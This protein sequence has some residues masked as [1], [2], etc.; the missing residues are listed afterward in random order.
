MIKMEGSASWQFASNIRVGQDSGYNL[1]GTLCREER[2]LREQ[3]RVRLGDLPD[4][5]SPIDRNNTT[6][7]LPSSVSQCRSGEQVEEQRG[8]GEIDKG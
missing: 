8:G 7:P 3:C 6:P 5:K 1:L 4:C 2:L